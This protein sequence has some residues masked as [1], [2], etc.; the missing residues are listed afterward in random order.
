MDTSPLVKEVAIDAPVS[1]VW[2]AITDKNQ[3]KEW[4]FDLAEFKPEVGFEFSFE[5]GKEG[6]ICYVHLC[7]ITEVVPEKKL[8]YSW[9][10]R[11]Y[12][13]MSY[14]TFEL[15]DENGKTKLVLTHEGLHTFPESNPDLA[16][17]NFEEGWTSIIQKSLKE[18]LENKK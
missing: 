5:G 12:E 8:T 15:F 4:Y 11:G 2:Q 13:G 1:R 7:K 3:M 16:R 17:H 9:K 18:Y 6:G 14:V 10:Y